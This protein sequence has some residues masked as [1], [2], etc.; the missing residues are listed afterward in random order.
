MDEDIESVMPIDNGKIAPKVT[1]H[2]A[3]QVDNYPDVPAGQLGIVAIDPSGMERPNS[4]FTINANGFSKHYKALTLQ[5][6]GDAVLGTAQ[7]QVKKN[8]NR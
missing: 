5:P 2:V 4:W 8:P 1:H 3:A 6:E 7:F